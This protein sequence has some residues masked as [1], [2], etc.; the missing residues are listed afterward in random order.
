MSLLRLIHLMPYIALY[1]SMFTMLCD[2]LTIFKGSLRFSEKQ[3][4]EM[5]LT[6][7]YNIATR[8]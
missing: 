4:K 6:I 7:K 8:C 2:R 3:L 5:F 1:E